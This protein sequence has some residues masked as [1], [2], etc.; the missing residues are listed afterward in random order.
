[1]KRKTAGGI[2]SPITLVVFVG[3]LALLA[4]VSALV[5]RRVLPI[6]APQEPIDRGP[7]SYFHHFYDPHGLFGPVGAIDLALDN[8]QRETSHVILVAAFVSMPADDPDFTLHVA[9][10]WRPGSRGRDNG[11]VLF[12]FTRD[13]HIRAEVG[14]G[15]EEA[16]PDAELF[17]ILQ[18]E[19]LPAF[20]R[21][22]FVAGLEQA[23]ARICERLRAVAR[24]PTGTTATPQ[25]FLRQGMRDVPRFAR[26]AGRLWLGATWPARVAL[27]F[28][29]E[30]V[31]A[32][33]VVFLIEVGRALR[34]VAEVVATRRDIEGLKA[35]WDAML[36]V[37]LKAARA[38]VLVF[39]VSLG[40]SY[41]FG[42]AGHFGGGGVDLPW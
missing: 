31:G 28:M 35:A 21:D 20:R 5:P 14:Y 11:L 9:E 12:V 15:L 2:G 33:V 18:K 42:G 26:I 32:A 23:M 10:R 1:V 4:L 27:L 36:I 41:F 34:L 17:T 6:P 19:A 16:L 37:G 40:G 8:F 13:R 38:L 3:V 39:V 29:A 30:L 7:G 24:A 22:D 25:A